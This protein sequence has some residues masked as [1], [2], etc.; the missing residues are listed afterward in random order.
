M[1]SSTQPKNNFALLPYDGGGKDTGLHNARSYNVS[2]PNFI[3]T[4]QASK[5]IGLHAQFKEAANRR[6]NWGKSNPSAITMKISHSRTSSS[7]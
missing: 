1:V 5:N 3:T 7:G 4:E 6:N 2:R